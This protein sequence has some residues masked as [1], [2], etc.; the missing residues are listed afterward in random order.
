MVRLLVISMA[1]SK[2]EFSLP[3]TSNDLPTSYYLTDLR[4]GD[5]NDLVECFQTDAIAR[6]TLRIP[7]PYSQEDAIFWIEFCKNQTI[8][9]GCLW[10]FVIRTEDGKVIG[11]V[12]LNEVINGIAE[13]GYWLSPNYWGRGI[14]APCIQQFCDYIAKNS[15]MY[16]ITRFEAHVFSTNS[17]SQRVLEKCGFQ[18]EGE[19]PN[20]YEKDGVSIDAK[21]Y[22]KS[23][24]G[25]N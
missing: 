4:D 18:Y 15:D 10:F 5:V 1:G 3:V 11:A 22:W 16:G 24:N 23:C 17:Q 12:S 25:G 21:I 8:E 2:A 6:N 13:I 14:M 20:K 9:K 7:Y 19:Y